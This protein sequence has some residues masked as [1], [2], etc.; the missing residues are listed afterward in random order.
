MV[1]ERTAV[2]VNGQ[3]YYSLQELQLIAPL[4]KVEAIRVVEGGEQAILHATS[5]AISDSNW[6]VGAMA[7]QWMRNHSRGRT[8]SDFGTL[9]GLSADQVYQR[10]RVWEV[11]SDVREVYPNLIWSHFYAAL[12]WD[13]SAECLK[14]ANDVQARVIEMRAWHRAQNGEDLSNDDPMTLF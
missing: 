6:I 5:R 7:A 14:W 2:T 1:M 13:D 10:R 3:Q 12:D 9:T 4:A 11:F 8:D